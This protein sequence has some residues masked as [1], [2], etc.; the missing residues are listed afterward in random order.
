MNH[1]SVVRVLSAVWLGLSA[2][3]LIPLGVAVAYGEVAQQFALA[4]TLG[5]V[6]LVA[7][8]ILLLTAKPKRTARSTDGLAVAVLWWIVTPVVA[9][10]P[11]VLGTAEE[12]IFSGVHEAMSCL[13]TSGHTVITLG[14]NGWPESLLVYRAVLHLIGACVATATAASVFAAINLGGAGIHRTELFTIPDESFFDA[15]P[16]VVIAAAGVIGL[17]LFVV[18]I[19]IVTATGDP[20]LAFFDAVSVATTG[21]VDPLRSAPSSTAHQVILMLGLVAATVGLA[22]LFEIKRGAMLS[23]IRDPE[24]ATFVVLATAIIALCLM[25]GLTGWEALGWTISM[26]STSGIEVDAF[27]WRD[28]APL[29]LIVLPAFIGG[30]GLS[31]AGGV[32]LGRL[33]VLARRASLEFAQLG[34]PK[35]KLTLTFRGRVQSQKAVIGVWVYLIGYILAVSALALALAFLGEDFTPSVLSAVGATANVGPLV[36]QADVA[37]NATG[38]TIMV[39]AQILGRLEILAVLPALNPSFWRA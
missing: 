9:G 28:P 7:L 22:V 8:L 39:V 34:Y 14:P 10:V 25:A 31:A 27:N 30:S 13:G 16:R 21:W 36:E 5:G 3:M 18:F 1:I 20:R 11:F 38:H 12:S 2:L 35:S 29:A 23:A 32:K 33:F 19:G 24:W 17:I 4:A 26:V 15:V 6:A 37:F